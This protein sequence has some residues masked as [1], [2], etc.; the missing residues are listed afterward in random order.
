MA[1]ESVQDSGVE[2]TTGEPAADT[3]QLVFQDSIPY[4][5]R[6]SAHPESALTWL[7]EEKTFPKMYWASR[8][9]QFEFAGVGD[10]FKRPARTLSFHDRLAE[11]EFLLENHPQ[12][13]DLAAFCILPFHSSRSDAER[14][15]LC[16]L[17]ERALVRQGSSWTFMSLSAWQ[18]GKAPGLVAVPDAFPE[19]FSDLAF[20]ALSR[21]EDRPDREI[22][23]RKCE[24]A[25]RAIHSGQIEKI[26]LARQS[27]FELQS[28]LNPYAYIH[29]RQ[30]SSRNMYH[31]VFEVKPNHAFFGSS[32]EL[33]C[34]LQ[35]KKDLQTEALAGTARLDEEL[36]TSKNLD[37]HEWVVRDLRQRL[38]GCASHV[39]SS[40]SPEAYRLSTLKHLRTRFSAELREGLSFES[41]LES[42]QPTAAV[43]G[44]PEDKALMLLG[45]SEDFQ[46]NYY[47]GSLG[48]LTHAHKEFAV[49]L[50]SFELEEGLLRAFTGAGL[51]ADSSPESEWDELEAKLHS[52]LEIFEHT[53]LFSDDVV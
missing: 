26:V 25:L 11:L 45:E 33:L 3:S 17:P 38:A 40:L 41:L 47:A 46:R 28:D 15:A 52:M 16:L 39:V 6:H 19:A 23:L 43:C 42:L 51:V 8:D 44:F 30:K 24:K 48:F 13:S 12:A 9:G 36:R 34:R 27:L 37:E 18:Q 49:S 21:V 4:C 32:P 20:P 22:W 35:G 7:S 31:F 5:Y 1:E 2:M 10:F 14:S 53:K 29:A 50:R